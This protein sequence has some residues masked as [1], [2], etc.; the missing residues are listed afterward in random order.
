MATVAE[1]LR[2]TEGLTEESPTR[3]LE[4][5]LGHVLGKSRTWLYTWPES[6]LDQF[7]LEQFTRLVQRRQRGEPVAYLIGQR[8][9][10]SLS[11]QVNPSTLI[12]R[13]ETETLVEWALQLPL[14]SQARALDLGTG[15]GAIALALASE[16]PGWDVI[17]VDSCES[18]VELA[19]INARA[20]D[21]ERTGFL[22][23]DWF[24]ALRGRHFEL[25]VSNPPYVDEADPHLQS[26]DVRFEPSGAL[27]AENC[28][29]ADL[30]YIVSKAPDYLERGGW[31]L[32]EHGFEQGEAV[33]SLLSRRGFAGI[34][35][36]TD[37]AGQERIS[38]GYLNAQ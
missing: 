30:A 5:L 25:I 7:Q 10:W 14:A 24:A 3:D 20:N 37:L 23:S 38:G 19:R 33:R 22:C 6:E 13:P 11:L 4:I 12:P 31:L 35:T 2:E 17:G 16:R 36:R 1:L 8:D 32:L 9:F 15:S 34:E 26:G 29:I 28:G 27:V 18:A 21:L